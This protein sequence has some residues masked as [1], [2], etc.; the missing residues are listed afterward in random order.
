[1]FGYDAEGKDAAWPVLIDEFVE[2]QLE[3]LKE[4]MK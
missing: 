2:E 4:G 1:L 3:K